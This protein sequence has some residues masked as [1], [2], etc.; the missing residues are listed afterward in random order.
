MAAAK[1]V[2]I[3]DPVLLRRIEAHRVAA[4]DRSSTKT[5]ARLLIERMTQLEGTPNK[6]ATVQSEIGRGLVAAS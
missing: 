6:F 2:R 3:T 4:G 1:D 5:A